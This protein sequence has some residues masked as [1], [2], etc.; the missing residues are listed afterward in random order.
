M[1]ELFLPNTT[2]DSTFYCAQ[3]DH[4]HAQLVIKRPY[5]DK[6]RF[7][8]DNARP[9]V[10]NFTRNKLIELGWELLPHPAYSLDLAP[11]NYHLLR[12]LQH[13][14]DS[15]SYDNN[16]E[17]EHDLTTFFESQSEKFW[18]N[19]THSLPERWQQVID[20]DG[21]YIIE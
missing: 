6:V 9:Y 19:G 11:T 15:K 13:H 16:E 14:L 1:L 7:L 5:L 18:L 20:S 8:H 12:I 21:A 17:V 10:S 2:I 3:F 4:L